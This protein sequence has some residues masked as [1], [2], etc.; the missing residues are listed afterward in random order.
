MSKFDEFSASRS[1]GVRVCDFFFFHMM[2]GEVSLLCASEQRNVFFSS[3]APT[4]FLFLFF[5]F[6]SF[7]CSE[8][9]E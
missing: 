5:F 6:F 4:L 8:R 9:A 2:D 3:P 7:C 1:R